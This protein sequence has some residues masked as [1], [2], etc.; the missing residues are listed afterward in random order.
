MKL[1]T[2]PIF[3]AFF[4]MGFGDVVGTLVGF[5][6]KEFDLS[7]SLAG[8][9]PFAGLIPFGLFSVPIGILSDRKGKKYVLITFL[10]IA[11]IGLL[12]PSI[13]IT[14]YYYVLI[15]I[16]MVGIGM[17]GLQV[18]GNPAMRDVSEEGK[19][20]RNLTFAQFIKSIGTN[21]GPYVVPLIVFLGLAWQNIFLIYA[22]VVAITLFA[23]LPLKMAKSSEAKGLNSVASLGSSF[24]LL[25]I[26]RVAFM[27]L[28]IFLYVGAEVGLNSWI[29]TYLENRFGLDIERLATL[30]I[31]FFLT[32]LVIGRLLGSI[33]LNYLSPKIF[34]IIS[35]LVGLVGV[36]GMFMPSETIV[37]VS[38]FIAGIGFGNI[39][40]L[41]FS[42]L[43]DSMPER[44]NELSGLLVMAI[45]GGAF[46]PAIMGV[47]A[48]WSIQLSF[49]IPLGIFL[50]LSFLAIYNMR[51]TK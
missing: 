37:I 48:E 7:S 3:L 5:A 49:L 41:I 25:K 31:G 46:I 24:A 50:Y 6:T 23:I 26:P 9:L 51:F 32:S 17:C 28:G 38:I 14:Q 36:L 19:Y 44:D 40:P 42:I 15:A 30:G 4:V 10:L 22:I 35:S 29:A 47:V 43:I 18:A 20:S 1:K 39:F 45:V 33:I 11:L 13:S 12:I 27:V 2:L 16:F 21:T 8:L 34:F